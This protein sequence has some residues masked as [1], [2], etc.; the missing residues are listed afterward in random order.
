M[1][2]E[3]F[4]KL[5]C[6]GVASQ[7]IARLGGISIEAVHQRASFLRKR[8]VALPTNRHKARGLKLTP[9]RIAALNK[10][11]TETTKERP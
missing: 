4:V 7:E 1:T 11:V 6:E 3:E 10:I 5:W 8:G 2:N 9:E